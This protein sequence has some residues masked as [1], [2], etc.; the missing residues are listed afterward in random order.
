MG[1]NGYPLPTT[2]SIDA[3]AA[4]GVN[5]T[6]AFSHST[7]TKPSIA[8]L[9]TS[10]YPS[11]HGLQ[12]VGVTVGEKFRVE[13]L[14]K[15]LVTLAERFQA[16]GY[17]TAGVV[18]QIHLKP[19]FGFA[20]GFDF[21]RA[22][23]G[24]SAFRI[25]RNFF[26]WMDA[27]EAEDDRPFF[28]YVHY[29]DVH[30]PYNRRLETTERLFGDWAIPREPPMGAGM[31]EEWMADSTDPSELEALV[32]RY[33]MEVSFADH[34]IGELIHHLEQRGQWE[35]TVLVVTSDH[36]EGFLEH[37]RL[38]HGYEPYEEV[39]RIPL[40]IRLPEAMRTEVRTVEAPVGLIDLMPTLLDLAGL[41]PEPQALGES[42]RPFMFGAPAGPRVVFLETLEMFA[43]R[44]SDAKLF[45]G[46]DGALEYFDLVTDRGETRPR[47]PPCD[48]P[49]RRLAVELR[50]F[51]DLMIR[52]R[53]SNPK[54]KA[55]MT[56]EEIESLR[57][58]GYLN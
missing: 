27:R 23:R 11:Q 10:L 25:N 42:V 30:W 45:R 32:A 19:H 36:G 46:E 3:L 33:D 39:I 49:C 4:E 26:N 58:L 55:Y 28:G 35:D 52:A 21:Y 9:M 20:Q 15:R 37:G 12:R 56:D 8:T 13:V 34:A 40:V 48:G 43:A 24:M 53:E 44:S 17:A 29:L 41:D 6:A 18:N 16:A 22:A 54:G 57:A 5:F 14:V 51:R 47:P 50:S 7:W 31:A 38:Q 1:V 2:P